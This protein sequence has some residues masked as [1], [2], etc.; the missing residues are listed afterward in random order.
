MDWL[1][2][3]LAQWN[4]NTCL[5]YALVTVGTIATIGLLFGLLGGWI[6][7]RLGLDTSRLNHK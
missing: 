7:R 1:G 5:L 3:V 4:E 2:T 6:A